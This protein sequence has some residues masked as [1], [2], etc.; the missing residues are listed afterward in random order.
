LKCPLTVYDLEFSARR[1]RSSDWRRERDSN[2]RATFWAATRFPV[3]HLRP[4]RSSLRTPTF[5]PSHST[6]DSERPPS[7]SQLCVWFLHLPLGLG[8]SNGETPPRRISKAAIGTGEPSGPLAGII[9]PQSAPGNPQSRTGAYPRVKPPSRDEHS[10]G[11]ERGIRTLGADK[12][13]SGFRDRPIQPA[14]ASL[15]SSSSSIPLSS[16]TASVL[17][18]LPQC[19]L[20]HLG[21]IL[22]QPQLLFFS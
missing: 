9:Q 11:G 1:A 7:A 10:N 22:N 21:A 20:R 4:T 3:V 8:T 13:L 14:L 5:G 2:P 18:P 16:R 12:P 17:G 15:R 19:L 6:A